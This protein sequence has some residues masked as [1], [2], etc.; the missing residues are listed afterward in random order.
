MSTCFRLCWNWYYFYAKS[1]SEDFSEKIED[2][3]GW[4]SN[5]I[6]NEH[7]GWCV[8]CPGTGLGYGLVCNGVMVTRRVGLVMI[9][10]ISPYADTGTNLPCMD[11]FETY[12]YSN[13]VCDIKL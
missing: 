6:L 11:I 12:T 8:Q 9:G 5:G 3:D 13:T 1:K 2:E 4:W 10:V 7:N